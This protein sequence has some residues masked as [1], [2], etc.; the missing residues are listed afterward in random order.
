MS[1][2][3]AMVAMSAI[4]LAGVI[5]R[6]FISSIDVAAFLAL[7]FWMELRWAFVVLMA[8]P[9]VLKVVVGL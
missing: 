7:A 3:I 9:S 6:S 1:F 8:K 2:G 5:G 4:F